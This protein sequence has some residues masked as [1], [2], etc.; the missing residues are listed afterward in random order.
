MKKDD[1]LNLR[2]P[3]EVK[4]KANKYAD[5]KRTSLTDLIIEFLQGLK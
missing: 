3:K 4:R 5:K 1:R 2:L